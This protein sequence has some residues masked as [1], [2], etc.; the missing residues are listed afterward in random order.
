MRGVY[1]MTLL[2]WLACLRQTWAR[3]APGCAIMDLAGQA[4]GE[5]QYACM[6]EYELQDVLHEGH[7]VYRSGEGAV[8]F[9]ALSRNHSLEMSAP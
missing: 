8:A 1:E 3:S 7:P 4:P 2:V 6:G 9:P 5:A